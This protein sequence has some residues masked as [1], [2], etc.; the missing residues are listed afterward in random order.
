MQ[1]PGH[2]WQT[3]NYRIFMVE[4]QG[5]DA[6]QWMWSPANGMGVRRLWATVF[7]VWEREDGR[8]RT[9]ERR[10]KRT[11]VENPGFYPLFVHAL[12]PSSA[13]FV[14]LRAVPSFLHGRPRAAVCLTA[15]VQVGRSLG[16]N[17]VPRPAAVRLPLLP[18]LRLSRSPAALRSGPS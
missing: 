14:F 8:V 4:L 16:T 11:S 12:F 6:L 15:L 7:G 13:T 2:L 5:W 1:A 17:S 9:G 3:A 10:A 18:G